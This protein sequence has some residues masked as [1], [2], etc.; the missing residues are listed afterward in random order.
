MKSF[1]DIIGILV[2]LGIAVAVS[3]GFAPV[4]LAFPFPLFSTVSVAVFLAKFAVIVLFS[5]TPLMVNGFVVPE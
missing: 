5:V 2:K 4:N 3:R 1:R